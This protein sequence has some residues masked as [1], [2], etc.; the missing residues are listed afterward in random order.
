MHTAARAI[1]EPEDLLWLG[2]D[3]MSKSP[4]STN[5][6]AGTSSLGQNLRPCWSQT[7]QAATGA[8]HTGLSILCLHLGPWY[9]PIQNF[10][11]GQ[12][13]PGSLLISIVIVTLEGPVDA[14]DMGLNLGTMSALGSSKSVFQGT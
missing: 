1:S 11:V 5:S 12:L 4:G 14:Q 13:Q 2:S 3:L 9:H 7:G 8:I 6:H 10:A